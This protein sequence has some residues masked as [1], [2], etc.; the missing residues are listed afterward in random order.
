[1]SI[2]EYNRM[3]DPKIS[4]KERFSILEK[5]LP[6]IRCT[7]YTRAVFITLKEI[8]GF[9][10]ISRYNFMEISE[11]MKE[12]NKAGMYDMIILKSVGLRRF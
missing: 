11:K 4:L 12:F 8:Y 1:M 6:K 5:Y 7:S 9:N 3:Q 2:S 10:D